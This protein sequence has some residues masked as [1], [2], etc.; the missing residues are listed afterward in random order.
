[1]TINQRWLLYVFLNHVCIVLFY[2]LG[3]LPQVLRHLLWLRQYVSDYL[4]DLLLLRVW[5]LL[6]QLAGVGIAVHEKAGSVLSS[7][8]IVASGVVLL[9][10]LNVLVKLLV[11]R[12]QLSVKRLTHLVHFPKDEDA[13]ALGGGL[14]LANEK[15]ERFLPWGGQDLLFLAGTDA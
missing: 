5:S 2:R 14:R 7:V 3:R 10:G 9:L 1:M 13:S 15:D 6:G 11:L 12:L 4:L 8:R